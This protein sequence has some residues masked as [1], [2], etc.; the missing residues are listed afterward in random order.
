[1]EVIFRG[2]LLN[3]AMK[4]TVEFVASCCEN[5]YESREHQSAKNKE[6]LM[7]IR[8]YL[9]DFRLQ[10]FSLTDKTIKGRPLLR[11][12]N[13]EILFTN[14][15]WL[16]YD[17]RMANPSQSRSDNQEEFEALVSLTLLVGSSHHCPLCLASEVVK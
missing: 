8:L 15:E 1:M 4:K 3:E 10:Y 2:K 14:I 5:L 9:V 7:L 6:D 13:M 11:T 16:E 12:D 17:K